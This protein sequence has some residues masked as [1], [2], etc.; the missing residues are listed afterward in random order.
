[1]Q[2]ILCNWKIKFCW[3]TDQVVLPCEQTLNRMINFD[4]VTELLIFLVFF[5]CYLTVRWPS[6]GHS[7]GDSLTNPM[8]ITAFVQVWPKGHREPR[9]EVGSLSSTD[10]LLGVWTGNLPIL[11]GTPWPTRPLSQRVFPNSS[12]P[13]QKIWK[14][15]LKKTG[16]DRFSKIL[17]KIAETV[18][19]SQEKNCVR[20][21]L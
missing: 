3:R 7:Q 21:S 20:V 13:G 18:Q 15:N 10:R 14:W 17:C 19:S 16:P 9:N 2:K 6:F 8:L 4:K 5:N 1:M 12:H 11:I